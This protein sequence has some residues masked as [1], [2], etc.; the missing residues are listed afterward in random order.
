LVPPTEL[1]VKDKDEEVDG[2]IE[3]VAEKN[4]AGTM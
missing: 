1:K 4:T 2:M 3:D